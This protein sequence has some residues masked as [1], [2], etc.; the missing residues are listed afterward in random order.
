MT[1]A[2]AADPA[3][4]SGRLGNAPAKPACSVTAKRPID[5]RFWNLEERKGRNRESRL[6]LTTTPARLAD[7]RTLH[8]HLRMR[9]DLSAACAL[10]IS[11]A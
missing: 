11:L 8:P 7:L 10:S 6:S 1:S 9:S 5:V 2:H 4:L 3:S